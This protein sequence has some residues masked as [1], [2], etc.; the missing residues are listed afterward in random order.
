V[1]RAAEDAWIGLLRYYNNEG[2]EPPARTRLNVGYPQG[3]M[4]FFSHLRQWR[5]SG[6]FDG[7]EFR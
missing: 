1:T 2:A 6:R 7:L 4:P 5:A 3:P